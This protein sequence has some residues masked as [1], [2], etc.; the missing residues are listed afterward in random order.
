LDAAHVNGC[1]SEPLEVDDEDSCI[2]ALYLETDTALARV[3]S[4]STPAIAKAERSG[5]IRREPNGWWEVCRVVDDWRAHTRPSLQRDAGAHRPWL[6]GRVSVDREPLVE[7]LI[8]RTRMDGGT[9]VAQYDRGAP[10]R[11]VPD[12]IVL[13]RTGTRMR[14]PNTARPPLEEAAEC[15]LYGLVP[16]ARIWFALIGTAANRVAGEC[17]APRAHVYAV[18]EE[19]VRLTMTD[20]AERERRCRCPLTETELERCLRG[21][22]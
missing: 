13:L 22:G 16:W 18:L 17:G 12:P 11:E 2:F 8:A 5:R 10:Y 20:V 1:P 14:E 15:E 4:V 6:D 7:E 21:G 3:L 9:V 19:E